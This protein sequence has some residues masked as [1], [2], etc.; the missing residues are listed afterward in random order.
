L[1]E[2]SVENQLQ[3]HELIAKYGFAWDGADI[4]GFASLFTDQAGCRFSSM[5]RKRLMLKSPVRRRSGGQ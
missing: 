5:V 4:E 2:L 1:T 3:I